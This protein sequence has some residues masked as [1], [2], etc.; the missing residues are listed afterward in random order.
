[1]TRAFTADR[2]RLTALRLTALGIDS[3]SAADPAAA[4]RHQFA[5]QSQDYAGAL[6]SIG[7]RTPGAT[8]ADVEASQASGAIVRS[9]PMRGTLHFVDARDLGWMLSLTGERMVLLSEFPFGA[10]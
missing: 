10:G 1:M 7:L 8:V 9:W 2:K 3:P 6:W 5:M 4:V